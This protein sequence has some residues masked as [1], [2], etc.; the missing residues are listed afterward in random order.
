[1]GVSWDVV[2][3]LPMLYDQPYSHETDATALR[4][5]A[6]AAGCTHVVVGAARAGEDRAA[7]KVAAVGEVGAALGGTAGGETRVSHGAHWYC[8]E[9]KSVGF[10]PNGD[11]ELNNADVSHQDDPLRISWNISGQR[12]AYRAGDECSLWDSDEW[13]KLVWGFRL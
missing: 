7:L 4:A 1:M 3:G 6:A 9:G 11:I 8:C 2:E 13:R 5:A 10:A 12:G